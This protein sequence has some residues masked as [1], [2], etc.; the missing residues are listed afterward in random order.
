[1]AAPAPIVVL[2]DSREG[3]PWTFPATVKVSGRETP[4]V[5]R[6]VA[7]KTGDYSMAG[8]QGVAT[9]ERKAP[10]D[11]LTSISHER[12]RFDRELA[13]LSLHR[14]AA[15][16]VEAHL[17]ELYRLSAMTP[18]SILGSV[19]SFYANWGTPTFFAGDAFGA[20]TLALGLLRR[21][22]GVERRR[23]SRLRWWRRKARAA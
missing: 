9:I 8:L 16:I 4:V 3:T 6:V 17:D 15:I 19:A 20:A 23:Q 11:F 22:A 13:R 18:A 21:W 14:F 10:G 1:M 5:T 7:L 2:Q 12:P